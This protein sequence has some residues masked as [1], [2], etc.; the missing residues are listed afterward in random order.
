MCEERYDLQQRVSTDEDDAN[1]LST[2][3]A[4]DVCLSDILEFIEFRLY[5]ADEGENAASFA[6]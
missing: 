5:H 3:V 1:P 4:V 6:I 2:P